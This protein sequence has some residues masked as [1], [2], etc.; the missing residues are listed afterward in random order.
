VLMFHDESTFR[1]GEQLTKR[2][3][4]KGN[5][6]FIIKGRGKS[7][8]VSDSLVSYPFGRFFN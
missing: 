2:W 8:M 5:E 7:L 4:K 1:C 6:P 3:F